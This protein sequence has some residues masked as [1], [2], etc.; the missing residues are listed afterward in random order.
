MAS[1]RVTRVGVEDGTP[2]IKKPVP[3]RSA[4]W[5]VLL[6]TIGNVVAPW[7]RGFNYSLDSPHRCRGTNR[8]RTDGQRA[9]QLLW[10]R[11]SPPRP[12]VKLARLAPLPLPIG[13]HGQAQPL[14][15]IPKLNAGSYPSGPDKYLRAAQHTHPRLRNPRPAPV[16]NPGHR[17]L[18]H[19]RTGT[20]QS[21]SSRKPETEKWPDGH[22]VVYSNEEN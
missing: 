20:L 7:N 4:H 11:Q 14:R 22:S 16:H 1:V 13:C 19:F 10:G 12:E 15:S 8:E 2:A 5:A 17:P 9:P 3:L 18:S 6:V 21:G